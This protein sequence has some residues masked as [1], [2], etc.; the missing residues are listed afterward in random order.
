MPT[1]LVTGTVAQVQVSPLGRL[2][3]AARLTA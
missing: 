2:S 1:Q 3:H